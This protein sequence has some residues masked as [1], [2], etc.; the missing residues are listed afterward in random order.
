MKLTWK[1]FGDDGL[2]AKGDRG[3]WVII[4]DG[5]WWHLSVHS[6]LA[7]SGGAFRCGHFRDRK[8]AQARA[9][10]SEDNPT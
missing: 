5:M 3:R 7:D 2:T 9:Q 4:T 10:R 6:V 8:E 1:S